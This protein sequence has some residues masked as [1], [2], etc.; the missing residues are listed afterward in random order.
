MKAILSVVI[1]V[2]AAG[3][4]GARWYF[5]APS[6]PNFRTMPVTRGD[7][8]FKFTA[9]GLVEPVE[10]IEVGRRSPAASKSWGRTPS[11]R[12]RRWIIARG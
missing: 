12:A 4:V 7:V 1:L 8:E 9:T 11:G 6:R 3:V 5:A 2:A 10:T